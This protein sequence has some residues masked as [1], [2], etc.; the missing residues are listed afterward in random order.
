[1]L[2]TAAWGGCAAV[3]MIAVDAIAFHSIASFVASC[4]ADGPGPVII[5]SV[6]TIPVIAAASISGRRGHFRRNMIP[7]LS[8]RR[9][10]RSCRDR[11]EGP[12]A[13]PRWWRPS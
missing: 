5:T 11:R 13:Q 8:S 7:S 3:V 12:R 1:M 9:R 4:A 10:R 6:V 2:I